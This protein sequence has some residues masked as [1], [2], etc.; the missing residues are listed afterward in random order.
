MPAIVDA[1]DES[2]VE[3]GLKFTQR[4][5][6]LRQG[7]ALLQERRQHR[8]APRQPVDEHRHAVG[9]GDV[10]GGI[11]FRLAGS[12]VRRAGRRSPRTRPM[13][14]RI[15][16]TSDTIRRPAPTSAAWA[17]TVRRCMRRPTGTVG[18]NGVYG[19]GASAFPTQTFNATNYWV[20]VVFDST[21]DTL[22]PMIAD[23]SATPIDSSAAVVTGRPT[24][25]R[26][27]ASTTRPRARSRRRR[28]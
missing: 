2:P 4:R 24:R 12:A 17:S 11:G 27:R 26:P 19:Y 3:L 13:S 16:P 18:G 21:P 9:D 8:H 22:A 23:V 20:D 14:C 15:T 1:G 7:R 5:Q 28:R 10:H 25:P 6:R